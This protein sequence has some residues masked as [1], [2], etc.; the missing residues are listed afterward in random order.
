[1][2][3]RHLGAVS[4]DRRAHLVRCARTA[5]WD[6]RVPSVGYRVA[7][8]RRP[9]HDQVPEGVWRDVATRATP[10]DLAADVLA[11][12]EAAGVRYVDL[13]FTDVMGA[14]KNVTIPADQ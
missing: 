9:S 8:A 1:L 3:S 6:R 7:W 12:A 2:I 14:V 10:A 11:Q 13:Q 4:Q 5:R